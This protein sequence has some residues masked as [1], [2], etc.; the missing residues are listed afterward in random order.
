MPSVYEGL[1]AL[2]FL[3]G[4]A[5]PHCPD[6]RPLLGAVVSRGSS[7]VSFCLK[8][9]DSIYLFIIPLN[10]ELFEVNTQ[11]IILQRISFSLG[12]VAAVP[13]TSCTCSQKESAV[14]SLLTALLR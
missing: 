11:E 13:L 7:S 8:I 12:E 1:F 3:P 14:C 9:L 2:V 5:R 4:P 6:Q 10:L